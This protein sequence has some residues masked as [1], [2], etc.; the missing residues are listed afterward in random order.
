MIAIPAPIS[1]NN[2][3]ITPAVCD[4]KITTASIRIPLMRPEQRSLRYAVEQS[5]EK[6]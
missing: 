6:V 5:I 2:T 4:A 1:P 3:I